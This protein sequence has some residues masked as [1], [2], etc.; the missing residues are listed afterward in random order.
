MDKDRRDFQ[1]RDLVLFLAASALIGAAVAVDASSLSNRLYEGLG[2]DVM[3]RSLLELPR[4][5]PGLLLILIYGAFSAFSDRRLSAISAIIAGAGMFLFGNAGNRLAAVVVALCVY[6][7]GIHLF[8]P[9]MNSLSFSFAKEGA[10]GRRMG[11]VQGVNSAALIAAAGGLYLLYRFWHLS[12]A[13]AYTTGAVCLIAAGVLF[14]CMSPAPKPER[15]QRIRFKK[16]YR[17]YYLLSLVNGARAQLTVTFVPWLLIDVYKQPVTT[18]TLLCFA[19]YALNVAFKPL[20][21]LLIDKKGERFVLTAE[22]CIMFVL[23]LGF[24]FAKDVLP[25]GAALVAVAACFVA[26]NLLFSVSMARA[27]YIKKIALTPADVTPAMFMGTTLNHL[28]SI[29]VPVLAGLA[30]YSGGSGGYAYV[31]MGGAAISAVN[32]CLAARVRVPAAACEACLPETLQED[33]RNAGELPQ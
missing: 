13:A 19:I 22:A 29:A 25:L 9:L 33:G 12:Y 30:W 32:I 31:F 21:G 15:Q 11:Q 28:F 3:Q 5:L 23:A 20:L 4:E 26:D 6:N 14:L 7:L 24:A 27:T 1:K 2:L 8:I 10:L 17:L 16:E 18:L